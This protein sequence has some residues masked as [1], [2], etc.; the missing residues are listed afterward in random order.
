MTSK[1][2]IQRL[3]LGLAALAL[4]ALPASAASAKTI[5]AVVSFTVLGDVV[6]NVGGNHVTVKSLVPPNGDPHDYSPSPQDAIAMKNAQLTFLSGEGL[7]TWFARLVKASGYQ[8]KPVIVSDGISTHKMNEDGKVVIDPHVWNAI[9][10]VE[11]WVK[12]I[13]AAMIKADP[14][15]AA[16][17]RKNAAAYL[18]KLK[19]LDAF[20]R[21]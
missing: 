15:D 16:D 8:G 13:E 19:A 1:R 11:I 9:P 18:K 4:L 6:K 3:V 7:E 2:L 12:N 21:R 14:E 5:H 10:N 20:R 17:F